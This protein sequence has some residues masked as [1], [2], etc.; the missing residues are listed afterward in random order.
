MALLTGLNP[1]STSKSP[2]CPVP[3]NL[4]EVTTHGPEASSRL[5][6]VTPAGIEEL[7]GHIEDVYRTGMHPALQV[8]V[9]H[10]NEIVLNRAIGYAAGNGP[11]EPP[12]VPKRIVDLETPINI[13]SASKAVT[14]M[15]VHKLAWEGVLHLDDWVSD[16]IPEFALHGKERLTLRHVLAHRAGLPN[17]PPD[18]LDLDLLGDPERVVE[19][20]CDTE[21][22]SRPGRILAYH[23]ITGGFVLGAV[24][25]RATGKDLR[26]VLREEIAEPLGLRWF[27]YGVSPDQV[28][29]VAL[30]ASTGPSPPPPFGSI[31]KRALGAS[32]EE[33]VELSNDVRFQTGVI[34]SANIFSTAQEMSMFFQCLLDGG[35]HDGKQVFDRRCV[36]HAVAEQ[37]WLEIDFTLIIPIRYGLGFMLGGK[38]F[39]LFGPD[40]EHAFGHIGLSNIYCWAD[41]ERKVSVALLNTGKPIAARHVLPLQRFINGIGSTFSKVEA[42]VESKVEERS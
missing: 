36:R 34:P 5:H 27:N 29:E 38:R 16:Y 2:T 1:F 40:T 7:W 19:I 31:L 37:S 24:I 30:N 4:D 15:L 6:G 33:C 14:A 42:N 9:R 18:A 22:R 20:L 26:D 32:L 28:D 35:M 10:E 11:G 12:D 23:A 17:L 21:L 13:F 8:C 25:E 41:P 39:G 3:T